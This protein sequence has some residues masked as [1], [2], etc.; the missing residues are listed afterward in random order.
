MPQSDRLSV[1]FRFR[2]GSSTLDTKA[3]DDI[4]RVATAMSS[5]FASRGLILVGFA[6]ST[7]NPAANLELSKNRA[8]SVAQQMRTRGVAPVLVTGFGQELPVADNSTE[9]G[10]EK[11]RRVEA[12]LRK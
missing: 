2:P 1:D 7:G 4:N 12:W 8:E 10:R 3:V 6:D 9:D 5:Q 11:N